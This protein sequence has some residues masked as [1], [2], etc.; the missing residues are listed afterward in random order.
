MNNCHQRYS[1]NTTFASDLINIKIHRKRSRVLTRVVQGPDNFTSDFSNGSYIWISFEVWSELQYQQSFKSKSTKWC[2]TEQ[3]RFSRY[4][5]LSFGI[6]FK[7]IGLTYS[8]KWPIHTTPIINSFHRKPL[9]AI[10]WRFSLIVG[11][12][13][14]SCMCQWICCRR[15][16]EIEKAAPSQSNAT[17]HWKC[18]YSSWPLRIQSLFGDSGTLLSCFWRYWMVQASFFPLRWTELVQW[19]DQLPG[20]GRQDT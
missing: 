3:L 15:G 16:E 14:R 9:F 20:S 10:D 13:A 18:N 7:R 4:I 17:I 19:R 1:N 8:R 12:W 5:R 2:Q 11:D 6:E